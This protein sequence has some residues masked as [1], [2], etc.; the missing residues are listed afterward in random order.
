M[1]DEEVKTETANAHLI[2]AAPDILKLLKDYLNEDRCV[3]DEADLE[4]GSCLAC[5]AEE[6]ITKAEGKAS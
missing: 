6:A 5:L 1:T 4:I 2:A 3:C